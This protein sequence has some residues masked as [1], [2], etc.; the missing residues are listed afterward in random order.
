[1]WQNDGVWMQEGRNY[2]VSLRWLGKDMGGGDIW[3]KT[4]RMSSNELHKH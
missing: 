2:N 4:C 1:M 3:E